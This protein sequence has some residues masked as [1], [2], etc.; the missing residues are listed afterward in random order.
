MLNITWRNFHVLFYQTNEIQSYI[1]IQ[2]LYKRKL[3]VAMKLI[4]QG[5]KRLRNSCSR[6]TVKSI[7][8]QANVKHRP[9]FTQTES[10]I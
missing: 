6:A 2:I 9:I 10:S 1:N 5:S 4:D 7:F 3:Q 8:K